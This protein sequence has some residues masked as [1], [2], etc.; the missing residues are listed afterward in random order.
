MKRLIAS[1]S[2]AATTLF[3]ASLTPLHSTVQGDYVEART[4]D[5][6][7]G[8]CFAN[9]EVDL[10]GNLA[11]FGWKINKGD[12]QGV[13]LDGLS[14]VGVV[15]ASGTLGYLL[16]S[17]FPANAVLIV[18]ERATPAQRLALKGF[19]ERMGGDLLQNIVSVD[20]AP[21]E[22][23]LKNDSIHSAT[24]KLTAG[25]LAMVETR[26][27]AERDQLC[28][29][30]ETWYPPLTKLDHAMPA[31]TLANTFAGKELGTTWNMPDKRSSFVGN[32]HFS[33]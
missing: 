1:V 15:K 18:D 29:N 22:F 11:V 30:E 7:T 12:W 33:E 24:A 21:I 23:T 25:T 28:H 4:A 27:M 17:P 14:V 19:A 13:K 32:F 5:V 3:G 26:A 8:P 10:V 16:R 31:Y 9:S 2:L 6:Y 20:S